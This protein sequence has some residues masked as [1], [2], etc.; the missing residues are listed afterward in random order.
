MPGGRPPKRHRNVTG[1]KQFHSR[2]P[3]RDGNVPEEAPDDV[4]PE[5]LS[6]F[7][8]VEL[9]DSD[10]IELHLQVNET[11]ES[12]MA[13]QRPNE[14]VAFLI[15]SDPESE[16][17]WKETEDVQFTAMLDSV[18]AKHATITTFDSCPVDIIRRFINRSWRFKYL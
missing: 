4:I 16:S 6:G 14:M 8:A 17:E 12:E 1:L 13:S 10:F 9:G 18:E 3:A 11:H 5:Q 15:E 7:E 2:E